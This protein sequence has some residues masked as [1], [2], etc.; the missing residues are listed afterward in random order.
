MM[1]NTTISM[2]ETSDRTL[3]D[4]SQSTVVSNATTSF[5]VTSTKFQTLGSLDANFTS[6][7]YAGF[8]FSDFDSVMNYSAEPTTKV[9]TTTPIH[10]SSTVPNV[11][12]ATYPSGITSRI[13]VTTPVP[14]TYSTTKVIDSTSVQET[15]SSAST[16]KQNVHSTNSTPPST[17]ITQSTQLLISTTRETTIMAIDSRNETTRTTTSIV[18]STTSTSTTT[19]S[20]APTTTST[21]TSS[22]TTQPSTRS[23]TKESAPTTKST[24]AE[25]T[26]APHWCAGILDGNRIIQAN[27]CSRIDE[28]EE[29][30]EEWT[31]WENLFFEIDVTVIL[32]IA[33]GCLLALIVTARFT[34]MSSNRR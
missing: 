34:N 8:N 4:V 22:T 9:L 32:F 2:V 17:R 6:F 1:P 14:T 16:T 13:L 10:L 7:D 15:Q 26:T 33:V 30:I 31:F 20:E 3:D 25:A 28:I 23:T 12:N 24:S 11:A 5:E 19:T 29:K 27:N 21:T 18:T